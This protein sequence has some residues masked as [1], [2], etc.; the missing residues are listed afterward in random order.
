MKKSGRLALRTRWH[1]DD[2]VSKSTEYVI[3]DSRFP[4]GEPELGKS[5][6]V[7]H[8]VLHQ[9]SYSYS[10]VTLIEWEV[11]RATA[12]RGLLDAERWK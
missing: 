11:R 8:L 7:T 1:F 4:G 10:W 12:E 5:K 2:E 3:R 9:S 6:N